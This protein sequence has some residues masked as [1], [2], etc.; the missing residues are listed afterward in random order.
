MKEKSIFNCLANESVVGSCELGGKYIH[1]VETR[2][3]YL[4]HSIPQM[5][6][7][8]VVGSFIAEFL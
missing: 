6:I 4:E 7:G 3:R 5:E 2:W 1:F 8:A